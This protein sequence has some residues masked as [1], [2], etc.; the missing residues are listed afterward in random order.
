MRP[1]NATIA[2]VIFAAFIVFSI[3]I[4]Y[5]AIRLPKEKRTQAGPIESALAKPAIPKTRL[6][7]LLVGLFFGVG[8]LVYFRSSTADFVKGIAIA[9][10]FI[11]Y[12]LGA[13]GFVKGLFGVGGQ[14]QPLDETSSV[15][16]NVETKK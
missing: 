9:I 11:A 8:S 1:E 3:F 13:E 2:S 7:A 12:S 15:P 4:I 10:V 5:K 6:V 14:S 16:D